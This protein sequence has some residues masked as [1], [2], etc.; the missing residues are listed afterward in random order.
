MKIIAINGSPRKNLNTHALLEKCL[1]GAKENGAET[2]LIHLSNISF[3]GC[4]SCFACQQ[5][6]VTIPVCALQDD[7]E[8]VLKKIYECDALVLG[9]PIYFGNVTGEMRS[10]LERLFFPYE[11]Y[12]LKSSAFG[13]KIKTAFVYAMNIPVFSLPFFRYHIL[14]NYFKKHLKHIFFEKSETLVVTSTQKSEDCSKYVMTIINGTRPLDRRKKILPKDYE[15]AFQLGKRLV[16][17]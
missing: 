8:A 1:D 4:R 13:K 5:K 10:F 3:K 7:L 6:N 12:G 16:T 11:S 15:K 17:R 14:I 9:S 2:E